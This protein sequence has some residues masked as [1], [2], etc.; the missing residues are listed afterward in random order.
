MGERELAS[1]L[2]ELRASR[3][4]RPP[5]LRRGLIDALAAADLGPGALS[6]RLLVDAEG[7][8]VADVHTSAGADPWLDRVGD[9]L[10]RLV[11]SPFGRDLARWN[12]T[13]PRPNAGFERHTV[14]DIRDA[15]W[16]AERSKVADAWYAPNG[17][18]SQLRAMM[19]GGDEFLGWIGYYRP[20]DA[21]PFTEADRRMLNRYVG[22]VRRVLERTERS[23]WGRDLGPASLVCTIDGAI[24]HASASVRG[25]LERSCFRDLI[26]RA[27][28]SCNPAGGL[29]KRAGEA[30]DI[31]ELDPVDGEAGPRFV[32]RV[33]SAE[34][35]RRPA[36][37][38]LTPRQL[39]LA[40]LAASGCTRRDIALRLGMTENTV[41]THL[42][43][44]YARLGISTRA[45]LARLWFQR[46]IG[47]RHPV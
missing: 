21:R 1:K 5:V 36:S 41:K 42:K 3:S 40:D 12:A 15:A 33:L 34:R 19:F 16:L 7:E 11:A 18:G 20:S 17:I 8:A 23:G 45:E 30:A 29:Q 43:E 37:V 47:R 35:P 2:E 6:Y 13:Y 4:A 27:V 9:N 14:H 22:E 44:I 38:S 39:E 26:A 31:L 28:K 24:V 46:D 32:V 25:Y 10:R